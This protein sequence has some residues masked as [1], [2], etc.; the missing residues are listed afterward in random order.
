ML[1]HVYLR[2]QLPHQR[3]ACFPG[4]DQTWGKA[5]RQDHHA[6]GCGAARSLHHALLG[7]LCVLRQKHAGQHN[8]RLRQK[9]PHDH[10]EQA[11]AFHHDCGS[12]PDLPESNRAFAP[13]P[14]RAVRPLPARGRPRRSRAPAEAGAAAVGGASRAAR[15]QE[16]TA[17]TPRVPAEGL[18]RLQLPAP[19]LGGSEGAE[20]GVR[21]TGPRRDGQHADD[22]GDT[23]TPDAPRVP[24]PVRPDPQVGLHPAPERGGHAEHRL[25][26]SLVARLPWLAVV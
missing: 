1:Q 8:H 20:R 9:R 11:D 7:G 2:I 18:C 3:R 19:V 21:D 14:V 22:D 4:A 13:E 15:G 23:D 6:R 26:D 10:A 17:K 16:A 12:H 5:H 24:R 25:P